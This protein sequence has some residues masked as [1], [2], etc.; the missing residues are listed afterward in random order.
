MM[1]EYIKNSDLSKCFCFNSCHLST[2]TW[3]INRMKKRKQTKTAKKINAFSHKIL[4]SGNINANT[5]VQWW[6]YQQYNVKVW[7]FIV[8]TEQRTLMTEIFMYH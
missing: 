4:F 7:R 6:I 1:I 8:I 2:L 5:K 3:I